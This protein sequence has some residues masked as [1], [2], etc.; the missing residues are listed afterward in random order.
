[1]TA[2]MNFML[3][4]LYTILQSLFT[5]ERAEKTLLKIK[6]KEN[7]LSTESD[8]IQLVVTGLNL[9]SDVLKS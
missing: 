9:A 1:M 5:V 3:S 7:Q 8:Q 6:R 2:I 4:I